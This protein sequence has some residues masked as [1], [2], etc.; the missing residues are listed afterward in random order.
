MTWAII[1]L[2]A[3]FILVLSFLYLLLIK[4]DLNLPTKFIALGV[5]I[6]FF[7]VQFYAL[8]QYSGW[9][10]NAALPQEFILIATDVHEPNQ[11]TGE[12]G[13][14]YWWIREHEDNSI[15]PR[16]YEL[17]Y[18]AQ[19]HKQ[20]EQVIKDQ[21]QGGVYVGKKQGASSSTGVGVS[22]EKIKKTQRHQKK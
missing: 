20:T 2:S 5:V 9:P 14:M 11:K 6:V 19:M 13:V 10:T 7:W 18:E 21:K 1:G 17:P 4:T 12:K 3:G 16:V 22:F 15:P 8:Q